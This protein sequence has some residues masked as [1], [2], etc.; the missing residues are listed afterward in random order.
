MTRGAETPSFRCFRRRS[1]DDRHGAY[2]SIR[3]TGLGTNGRSIGGG[4]LPGH[5][6]RLGPGALSCP[7]PDGRDISGDAFVCDPNRIAP[8]DFAPPLVYPHAHG[9]HLNSNMSDAPPEFAARYEPVLARL[10]NRP[11]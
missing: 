2:G 8:D 1:R 4:Q 7:P 9:A 5:G 6:G 3:R 11:R 10:Y